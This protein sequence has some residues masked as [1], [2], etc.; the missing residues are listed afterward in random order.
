MAYL[1][2]SEGDMLQRLLQ[3][4]YSD[5]DNN[6]F[7]SNIDVNNDPLVNMRAI[8]TFDFSHHASASSYAYGALHGVPINP[9]TDKPL[10]K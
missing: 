2:E 5:N 1:D 7:N 9:E 8:A 3:R 4:E 6:N 10:T